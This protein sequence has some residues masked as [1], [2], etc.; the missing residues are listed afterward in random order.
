MAQTILSAKDGLREES[1]DWA[2]LEMEL[3][4]EGIPSDYIQDNK[5]QIQSVLSSVVEAS[6]LEGYDFGSENGSTTGQSIADEDS[7]Y[8]DD[9]VSQ[10]KQQGQKGIGDTLGGAPAPSID[11]VFSAGQSFDIPVRAASGSHS[12]IEWLKSLPPEEQATRKLL[13]IFGF[14]LRTFSSPE[15][16]SAESRVTDTLDQEVLCWAAAKGN[17]LALKM[18]IQAGCDRCSTAKP[19]LSSSSRGTASYLMGCRS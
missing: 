11:A 18:L 15:I 9:S 8:A 2:M 7:I 5:P 17:E 3:K 12:K 13:K 4:T 14:D 16:P 19:L 1:A 6:H 10:V